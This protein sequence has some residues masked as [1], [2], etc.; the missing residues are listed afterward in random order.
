MKKSIAILMAF[1]SSVAGFAQLP[2]TEMQIKTAL[3]AARVPNALARV[4]SR[5]PLDSAFRCVWSGSRARSSRSTARRRS[6]KA[7]A[8]V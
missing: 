5:K 8:E 6:A 2:S 3:L 4:C 7:A 1:I